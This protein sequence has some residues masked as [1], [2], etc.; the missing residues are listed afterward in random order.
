MSNWQYP[1]I[2][3]DNGLAPNRRQAIVWTNATPILW[4][5]YTALEEDELSR[6]Q[7]TLLYVFVMGYIT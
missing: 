7:Q 5:I 2:A 1:S 6:K 4:H 3:L